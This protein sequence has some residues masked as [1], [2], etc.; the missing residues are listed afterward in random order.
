MELR[1]NVPVDQLTYAAQMSHI[2]MGNK[3]VA[4]VIKDV[5]KSPTRAANDEWLIGKL[6]LPAG[7]VPGSSKRRPSK[8]FGESSECTKRRKTMELKKNVP[9]D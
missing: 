4:R 6:L 9:V 5:T 7:P 3:N 1:Q 8:E 2:I